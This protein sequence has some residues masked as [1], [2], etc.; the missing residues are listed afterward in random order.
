MHQKRK[1]VKLANILN[2]LV[3][4]FSFNMNAQTFK[5]TESKFN[6]SQKG[7]E[8]ISG[9]TYDN[10]MM[11]VKLIGEVQKPGVHLLPANS[12]F[13]NLLSYAGGPTINADVSNITIKRR[14]GKGYKNIKLDFEEFMQ[15]DQ[16]DLLL[17]P[18]DLVYVQKQEELISSRTLTIVAT[19]LGIVVSGFVI[20]DKL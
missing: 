18:N 13:T 19:L 16:N 1:I 20:E 14:S 7:S 5:I 8:Y 15:N 11:E 12:K 10:R 6:S 2:L 17:K 3:L 4:L 9:T